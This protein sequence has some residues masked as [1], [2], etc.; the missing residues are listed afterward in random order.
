MGNITT[1]QLWELQ[2]IHQRAASAET[3]CQYHIMKPEASRGFA[4]YNY[5]TD[6]WPTQESSI[7]IP[8][9][10]M[11]IRHAELPFW[12]KVKKF[13]YDHDF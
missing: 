13:I 10:S 3:R 6:K 8:K 12:I 7:L 9:G 5:Y 1:Q 4:N 11:R 2:C